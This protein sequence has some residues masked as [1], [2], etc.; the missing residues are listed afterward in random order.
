MSSQEEKP[1]KLAL[2]LVCPPPAQKE[3]VSHPMVVW[4][5]CTCQVR[6][7]RQ[8]HGLQY[9]L[10]VFLF[11]MMSTIPWH[12][13]AGKGRLLADRVSIKSSSDD[14][15]VSLLNT[16][17]S[18]Q[19]QASICLFLCTGCQ[20]SKRDITRR[21]DNIF[22]ACAHNLFVRHLARFS[23]LKISFISPC[24]VWCEL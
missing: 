4:K 9:T 11:R 7:W 19:E 14:K 22:M 13:A 23:W 5:L 18:M 3:T 17:S 15:R 10:N 21:I 2:F 1:P 8:C 16:I 12:P 20:V 6:A 24:L